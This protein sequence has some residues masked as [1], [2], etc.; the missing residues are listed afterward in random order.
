MAPEGLRGKA[1]EGSRREAEVAREGGCVR[2]RCPRPGELP[3]AG[4]PGSKP[5]EPPGHLSLLCF[6]E[7][8]RASA[9]ARRPLRAPHRCP[10]A[11]RLPEGSCRASRP[12]FRLGG[13]PACGMSRRRHSDENDG[14]CPGLGR[15][16]HAQEGSSFG[17]FG[18]RVSS[19]G[20]E[21]PSLRER[22]GSRG[23]KRVV[24]RECGRATSEK[25][26]LLPTPPPSVVCRGA[27][28]WTP[29]L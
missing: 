5:A 25:P 23:E 6:R 15:R 16:G 18:L 24:Q 7:P 22:S 17:F 3:D 8:S 19:E 4:P 29:G 14:E 27:A 26:L 1:G 21:S 10:R 11:G 12:A 13:A 28:W 20:M 9:P 2:S